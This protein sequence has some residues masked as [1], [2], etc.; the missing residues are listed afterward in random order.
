MEHGGCRDDAPRE[1]DGWSI[2]EVGAEGTEHGI[3]SMA[4]CGC[5][6]GATGT[7]DG[8]CTAEDEAESTEHGIQPMAVCGQSNDGAP[9]CSQCCATLAAQGTEHGAQPMGVCGCYHVGRRR[10][11]EWGSTTNAPTSNKQGFQSLE[12]LSL[13]A[14]RGPKVSITPTLS[15]SLSL[16]NPPTSLSNSLT[17]THPP[18]TLSLSL[19]SS[20][21]PPTPC[22]E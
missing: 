6:D 17:L 9:G 4:G 3:Q 13:S 10:T 12:V 16:T 14:A 7:V 2:T 18:Q 21:K 5:R 8:W 15:L 22:S 20:G 19:C 11:G 1:A